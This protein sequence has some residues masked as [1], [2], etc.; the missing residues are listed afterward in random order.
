MKIEIRRI[1][2]GKY[3]RANTARRLAVFF[4]EQLSRE[5]P[6]VKWETISVVFVG[7]LQMRELYKRYFGMNDVSDVISFAYR[8]MPLSKGVQRDGEII[9]NVERAL[10]LNDSR[11][12]K[13]DG[14]SSDKELALYLAHG[15]DHLAGYDDSDSA[16]RRR[17]RA[18]ELRWLRKASCLGMLAGLIRTT[19]AVHEKSLENGGD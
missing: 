16:G 12:Q 19:S 18:R 14:W 10:K 5:T 3:V 7:D 1:G 2:K 15:F 13:I 11:L 17:M 9:V 6:G 4:A 8:P